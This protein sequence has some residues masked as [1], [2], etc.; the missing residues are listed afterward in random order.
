MRIKY[1]VL[2]PNTIFNMQNPHCNKKIDW[3]WRP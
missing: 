3:F 1:N 2:T